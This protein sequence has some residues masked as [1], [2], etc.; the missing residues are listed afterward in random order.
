MHLSACPGEFNWEF[1]GGGGGP[2]QKGIDAVTWNQHTYYYTDTRGGDP[3]QSDVPFAPPLADWRLCIA[4]ASNGTSQVSD[5]GQ[6][7]YPA[8][9]G[10]PSSTPAVR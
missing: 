6:F 10:F 4:N 5:D 9:K 2:V 1:F 3:P 7:T 8:V